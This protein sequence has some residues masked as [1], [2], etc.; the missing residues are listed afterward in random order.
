MLEMLG[1]RLKVGHFKKNT[2]L[3]K[4]NAEDF[5]KNTSQRKGDEKEE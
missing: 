2:K 4:E 3:A 1:L 5:T